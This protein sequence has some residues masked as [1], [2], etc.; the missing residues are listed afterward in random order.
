MRLFIKYLYR[1][2]LLC[3]S[4]SLPAALHL[5]GIHVFSEH[6]ITIIIIFL[7]SKHSRKLKMKSW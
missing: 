5:Q 7:G 3:L 1:K 6:Y 4:A 2:L